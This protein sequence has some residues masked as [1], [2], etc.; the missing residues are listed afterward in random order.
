ML[1]Q[2]KLYSTRLSWAH[3]PVMSWDVCLGQVSKLVVTMLEV[4]EKE[5]GVVALHL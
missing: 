5:E 1:I 4:S 2:S 3:T